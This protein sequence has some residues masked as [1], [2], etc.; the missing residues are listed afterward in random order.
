MNL[1][2]LTVTKLE[3]GMR[4]LL[5]G[6][7]GVCEDVKGEQELMFMKRITFAR[8]KILFIYGFAFKT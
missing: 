3:G 7:V 4:L 2:S 8:M 1:P 6:G 5:C